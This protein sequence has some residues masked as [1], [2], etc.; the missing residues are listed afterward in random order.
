VAGAAEQLRARKRPVGFVQPDGV[1]A[2]EGEHA[3]RP[4]VEHGRE[5][6]GERDFPIH[7]DDPAGVP[8]DFDLVV[9]TVAEYR[10]GAEP[11]VEHGGY[12]RDGPVFEAIEGRG[13]PGLAWVRPDGPA[14]DTVEQGLQKAVTQ[15]RTASPF[16]TRNE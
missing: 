9:R 4:R 7:A 15:H 10:Q 12:R 1:V 3:D 6:A 2:A 13:V 16:Q 11:G 8:A 5:P 14:A